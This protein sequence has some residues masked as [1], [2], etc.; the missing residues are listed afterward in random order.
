MFFATYV[1][2]IQGRILSQAFILCALLWRHKSSAL[3]S[4]E[5]WIPFT[6]ASNVRFYVMATSL[7]G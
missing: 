4:G 2:T 6:K 1:L 5:R 7:G 3:S